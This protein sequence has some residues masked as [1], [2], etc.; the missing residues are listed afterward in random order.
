MIEIPGFPNPRSAPDHGLLAIGGTYHPKM[1]LAAYASGIFPWP[2]EEMPYAWF[3]PD[4][5]LVLAPQQLHVPRSLR[6]LLRRGTFRVSYDTCFDEVI[7]RCAAAPRPQG[8]GTWINDEL[9]DGF[10]ALHRA[11]LAHSVETWR[12]EHLAGGLYGLSLGSMFFGESMFRLEPDASKVAFVD[13]V[14]RVGGWGFSLIDC[15]VHTEHL[16]RFGAVECPR[17]DFLDA[18]EEAL[19]QPTRRGSWTQGDAEPSE[20]DPVVA[21]LQF[22][23]LREEW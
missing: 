18:L 11:G 19:R 16:Q 6:K 3:S 2:H 8:E 4:P 1:L 13:L 15:Q 22:E 5:R 17:D 21:Q 7:R 23:A 12:G 9:L 20:L 14:R 10:R